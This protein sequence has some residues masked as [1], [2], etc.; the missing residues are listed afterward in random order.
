[1]MGLGKPQLIAKF[2]VAG[3]IYY[4]NIMGFVFKRQIHFL[5]HFWGVR[6]NIRTS[7]IAR[8]KAC[9][10]LPVHNNGTFFAS[11]YSLDVISRYWLGVGHLECKFYVEVD[12]PNHCWCQ[13]T[14]VF[15]LSYGEDRMILSSFKW[16]WYQCV[17]DGWMELPWLIECLHCIHNAA[18][19]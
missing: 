8:W 4:G 19:L 5:N 13:K 2:E 14:R 15:L 6:G 11:S 3:F 9:G 12:V 16:V 17:T 18:A 10:R 1:M 7:S